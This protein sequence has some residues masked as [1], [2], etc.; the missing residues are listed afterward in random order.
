MA[1]D[2]IIECAWKPDRKYG[3]MTGDPLDSRDWTI[4]IK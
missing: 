3:S 4:V 2:E 1:M